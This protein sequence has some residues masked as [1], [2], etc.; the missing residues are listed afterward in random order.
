[1][2]TLEEKQEIASL[3]DIY[4]ELL[5][6]RQR[7][8]LDLYYNEDLSYGE[9]AQSETISRQAVHD[10]IA[11]GRKAL[12]KFEKHLSLLSQQGKNIIEQS[13]KLLDFELILKELNALDRMTQEDIVYD[14]SPLRSRIQR[15]RMLLSQGKLNQSRF[16]K[17]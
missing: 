8:F 2:Q 13:G 17:Q 16:E 7:D 11:H 12:Q 10:T 9:I 14:T 5:T 1:M 15:L 6:D 3:L 4:G